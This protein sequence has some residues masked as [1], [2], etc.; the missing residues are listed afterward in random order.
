MVEN[1]HKMQLSKLFPIPT[2][3]FIA[4][5]LVIPINRKLILTRW[6]TYWIYLNPCLFIQN[7][8]I[9]MWKQPLIKWMI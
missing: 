8:H 9:W 7:Q 3:G 6:F 5:L 2:P 1:N 4:T